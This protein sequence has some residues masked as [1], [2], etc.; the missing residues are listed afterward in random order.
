A[1][2]PG[3]LGLLPHQGIALAMIGAALG[4]ANNDAGGTGITKHLGGEVAGMGTGSILVAILCA[5]GDALALCLVGKR[6]DQG[7]RRADQQIGLAGKST[8]ARQHGVE[9]G[10]G[11]L[12]AIH[13]PVAGDQRPNAIVHVKF[14]TVCRVWLA[15][16]RE[17]GHIGRQPI[18]AT[19]N[20]SMWPTPARLRHGDG[21]FM[22]LYQPGDDHFADFA[23]VS[24][25]ARP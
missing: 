6:R 13:F 20:R 18:P 3:G 7:G 8:R 10:R 1:G 12:Q 23:P 5:D 19:V 25:W 22:M 21:H 2:A 24:A 15:E 11:G 16:R 14:L 17:L 9:F 4:M